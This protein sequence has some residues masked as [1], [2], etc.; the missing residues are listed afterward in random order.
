MPDTE[1]AE[2]IMFT[3]GAS[4]TPGDAYSGEQLQKFQNELKEV[5]SCRDEFISLTVN[6]LVPGVS[7]VSR[8]MTVK[9][10]PKWWMNM[11]CFYLLSGFGMSSPIR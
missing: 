3:I 10:E 1:G 11:M 5:N 9:G 7:D 2:V 8:Q 6:Q 4:V